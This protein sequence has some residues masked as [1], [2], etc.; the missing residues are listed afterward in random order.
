ML[1]KEI[2]ELSITKRNIQKELEGREE[3]KRVVIEGKT[4]AVNEYVQ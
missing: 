2:E 1:L 3:I 4:E